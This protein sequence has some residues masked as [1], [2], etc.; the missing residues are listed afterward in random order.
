MDFSGFGSLA[1]GGGIMSLLQKMQI[2]G[3]A[4]AAPAAAPAVPADGAM[5]ATIGPG[6]APPAPAAQPPVKFGMPNGGILGLL[7]GQSPQGMM[8]LLKRTTAA[9]GAP[10]GGVAPPQVG[11]IPP[12]QTGLTAVPSGPRYTGGAPSGAPGT[13]YGGLMGGINRLL[14]IQQPGAA[15]A[16][17][18][19]PAPGLP[20]DINPMNQF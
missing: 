7:Q 15:P 20:T 16:P 14:G 5:P 19:P 17:A 2:G 18:Q 12:D 8:G 9:G 10:G 13:P 6:A 4:P 11:M 3:G 1:G